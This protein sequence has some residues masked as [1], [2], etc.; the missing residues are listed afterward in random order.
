[1]INSG[2]RRS[3][4][5]LELASDVVRRMKSYRS[6]A[7][8]VNSSESLE[9]SGVERVERCVLLMVRGERNYF[10]G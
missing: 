8:V 5:V 9:S 7:F 10:N 6:V 4:I 3:G 1:M 2:K